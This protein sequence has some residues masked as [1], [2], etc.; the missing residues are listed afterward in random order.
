MIGDLEWVPSGGTRDYMG[1]DHR[2]P[3]VVKE[4]SRNS[5]ENNTPSL[6]AIGPCL[7]LDVVFI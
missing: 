5:L 3:G 6:A 2:F 7:G 1:A 4:W